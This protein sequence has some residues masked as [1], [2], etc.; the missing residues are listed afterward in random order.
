[1]P[2]IKE[3]DWA[4]AAGFV[5]GEGCIAITRSFSPQR[6]RFYYGVAV[7]VSNRDRSVLDWFKEVWGGHVLLFSPD[8]GGKAVPAWN[9]RS[10]T[11]ANSWP[12]LSGI[13]PYL[14]IKSAQCTNA[15]AM[16]VLLRR[17]S[18][19]LGRRTLPEAWLREQE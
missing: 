2:E 10:L 6:N 9:W 5:D 1:M 4:Y 16:A 3:T 12:F 11:G 8:R 19:T 17:S 18:Y 7:V 13:R 15:L 14:R